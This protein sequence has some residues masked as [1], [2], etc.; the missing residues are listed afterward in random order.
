MYT[1]GLT[2][3]IASGKSTVSAMLR[4]LGAYIIDAD[5]IA[6]KIVM[7]NEPAWHDIVAHFGNEILLPDGRINREVLGQKIFKDKAERQCLE[8]IT[9]PYIENEVQKSIAHAKSIGEQ[10]VVLDVPLLFEV[11][12]GKMVDRIWVV[13]VEKEVQLSRLMDRNHLTRQ[14]AQERVDAQMSLDEKVKQAD[15]VINNNLD[16]EHARM[17]VAAAWRKID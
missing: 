13:Y 15:V 11:G 3:G 8:K 7:P 12:W 1:I 6:R 9:H 17:Q 2:G 14:Q 5:E 16:I 4:K 10:V